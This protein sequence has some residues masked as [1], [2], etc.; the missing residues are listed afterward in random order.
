MNEQVSVIVPAYN[1]KDN[2]GP[3][4]DEINAELEG[5][6]YE[7]LIVD[8]NSPD[9]TFEVA[10]KKCSPR[11]RAFKRDGKKG[12]AN[13]IR[14]GIEHS[15]G[16]IIVIMDSDFDHHPKYIKP[17]L[18][19]LSDHDC[20]VASRFIPGHDLVK[21]LRYRLSRLYNG[22]IRALT[23]GSISD[24]LFGFIT[25]R[26]STLNTLDFDLTFYGF[27]DYC[28]RLLTAL[29]KRNVSIVEIPAEHGA[30]V[31]GTSSN[32]LMNTFFLYT[33]ET[34]KLALCTKR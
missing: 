14:Y 5:Q 12:L 18:S 17:M 20:A 7:I 22:F 10:L 13:S 3:L 19:G 32:K 24:Y 28:M 11:V 9:G 26:R 27:G 16:E 4:I 2:I 29:E 34:I 33:K 8:D 21:K 15:S 31:R 25:L 30:R 6:N 1:E 23:G